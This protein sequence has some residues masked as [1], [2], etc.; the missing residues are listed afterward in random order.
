L[1]GQFIQKL[2]WSP[3]FAHTCRGKFLEVWMNVHSLKNSILL[4]LLVS[5]ILVL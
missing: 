4:F 1:I 3:W 2:I 5:F